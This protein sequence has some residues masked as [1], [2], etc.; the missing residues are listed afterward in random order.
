[1]SQ[2][3]AYPHATDAEAKRG[4]LDLERDLRFGWDMWAWAKLQAKTGHSSVYYYHFKQTP[5]FPADSVYAGWGASHYAELW[6]MFDHLS[7]EPWRWTAADTKL[8]EIMVRYWVNFAKS[9]N[10]N[11]AGLPNWPPFSTA[12][13]NVAYLADPITIGQ[14]ANLEQL[15]V[16]ESTY[17]GIRHPPVAH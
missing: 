4:R 7:Q 14:P 1:L 15:R 13:P 16:F 2:L 10:P 3:P 6:Y 17:D 11:E 8:A 9:G 5:P 12:N